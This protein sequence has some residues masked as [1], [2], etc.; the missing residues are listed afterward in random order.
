MA[1]FGSVG[2]QYF[3]DAGDP[4]NGGK[5][6]FYESN[7]STRKTTYSDANLSVANT[8]PVILTA[9]GRQPAIYFNGSARVVL[10]TSA[11]VQVQ[12]RDP[13]GLDITGNFDTW[14]SLTVYDASAIVIG[15]DGNYYA[16][17]AGSNQGN[18]PTTDPTKWKQIEFINIWNTNVT[19]ALNEIVKASNSALY[20]S[21]TAG[22]TG[23][24]PI[25]SPANWSDIT[26]TSQGGATTISSGVDITLTS[27]SDK[28][29]VVTMTAGNLAVELPAATTLQEGTPIYVISN[30]GTNT[31]TVED[32]S[33][34][35]IATLIGGSKATF[36]LSDNTTSAGAWQIQG[37]VGDHEIYMTGAAGEGSSSTRI[38]EF[39]NVSRD[40]G[41][42]I[43]QVTS[44]TLGTVFTINE[45]AIYS[46]DWA[47]YAD[48]ALKF[49]ISVNSSELTVNI[50]SLVTPSDRVAIA[51]VSAT[52]NTTVLSCTRKF[53]AG[54]VVRAHTGGT[55]TAISVVDVWFRITKIA[56]I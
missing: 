8:N 52:S 11:D 42:A 5:L 46:I 56:D 38:R 15:S 50:Q 48:S 35:V 44:S 10:T 34:S 28:V 14:N 37:G 23:N 9:S 6:N 25:S 55:F 45:T 33:G 3:D 24:D 40:A 18:D 41:T 51:N 54:D 36:S 26:S 7:T 53:N 22:N 30:A 4:L 29:Q 21:L 31:F 19:Y 13:D 20:K 43:T 27:A 1:I 17:F 16:S 47:D 2:T 12:E 49:G 39:S 32:G